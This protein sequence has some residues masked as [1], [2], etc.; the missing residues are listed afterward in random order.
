MFS[1]QSV[2]STLLA[3]GFFFSRAQ[4]KEII[5]YGTASQSEAETINREEKPSDANGQLGWGLYLTDVPPRRSLYKNPW[6]C[7][8]KANVD[9]IKDLS[10]VW[11]PESYD[12]ITFTGRRPTQLW[13]EDE[14]II[15]EYVETKVPDPKKALRFTHNPEDSSKLRM[16]IPTDLM[17]DDDLGLWARCW[18]T[19][20]ELMDYSRGESL[21]WTD[22]Q[23]VG[24]PK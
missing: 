5:G 9:K 23:I 7:V 18:E 20:N 13:Y 14:E 12:Q 6:H 10:K 17:H 8:V 1:S 16:V 11:I 21:D 22:W 15:I 4:G 3:L 19:K 24:F 2:C